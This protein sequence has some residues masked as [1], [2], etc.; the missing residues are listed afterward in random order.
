LTRVLFYPTR[1]EKIEKYDIFGGNFP[2]SNS[3]YK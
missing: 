3:N 1:R 2:N